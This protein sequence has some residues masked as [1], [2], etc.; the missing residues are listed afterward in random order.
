MSHF[1]YKSVI[2][3]R[4]A[5][6]GL[7][8]IIC[9]SLA[10]SLFLD[11]YP[12]KILYVAS[13]AAVIFM[14]VKIKKNEFIYDKTALVMAATLIFI[15]CTRFTWGHVFS[16]AHFSDI[17]SN[18]L[19][20]G[21][22]FL[23]SSLLT[24]F[25]IAW[26]HFLSRK[27]A[28][29]GF[30][31]LFAGLLL[32]LGFSLHEHLSTGHRVK[33]LS[34]SA[35]TISYLMTA[36]ALSTMFTGYRALEHTGARVGLFLTIFFI[37]TYLLILTE[38]RAGVLTL[39]VLYVL[40]F[41]VTHPRLIKA[42]L[43]PLLILMA[44]VFTIL[45]HSVWQRLD[46]IRT[47][48]SSYHTNNDTSI[49]ARFSIWKGGIDSIRWTLIGQSPDDRTRKAREYI[50]ENERKNPEAYKNVQYH[51]HDDILETLSLQGLTGGLSLLL[52]Y[53]VLFVAPVKS[54]TYGLSILPVSFFIFGLTDTVLIQSFSVTVICLAV[55]VSYAL[56]KSGFG[57]LRN[58]N[59]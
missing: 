1:N 44:A 46:N 26:R 13:Y 52:F 58:Q 42:A 35:G 29:S 38:S 5:F 14:A 24:Y 53:L 55:I 32:T 7:F 36:L 16:Q 18:Y 47:E 57:E 21:K 10:T 41:C 15:G 6:Q 23:V 30:A 33:L 39:P 37:N 19:M 59:S 2:T 31:I 25:F 51:L 9:A 40:F 27:T 54:R 17:T 22:I 56:M 28:L 49:G 50:T 45:P 11:A 8:L 4:T 34:D 3:A 48:V 20:G 12:R 43:I